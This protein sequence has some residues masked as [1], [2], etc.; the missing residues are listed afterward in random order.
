MNKIF[1]SKKTIIIL[2]LFLA[3]VFSAAVGWFILLHSRQ[4]AEN[5][6][7]FKERLDEAD[8][9]ISLGYT[10]R[11]FNSLEKALELGIS[12]YSL[13]KVLKRAFI[14]AETENRYEKLYSLSETALEKIPGSEALL[15]IFIYSSLRAGHPVMMK[16]KIKDSF[17]QETL[18]Y[19]WAEAYLRDKT[20]MMLLDQ[21]FSPHINRLIHLSSRKN[22]ADLMELGEDLKDERILLDTALLW[23][24]RGKPQEAFGIVL[25]NLKDLMYDETAAYIAY[26]AGQFNTAIE[27]FN[28]LIE[29]Y[30]DR[31]DLIHLSGDINLILKRNQEAKRYYHRVIMSDPD[32]SWKPYLNLARLLE[33]EK[34]FKS[35]HFYRQKAH[36]IFPD[37]KKVII[38]LAKS[39]YIRGDA[40]NAVKILNPFLQKHPED[41]DANMLLLELNKG[42]ASP[43]VYQ[44][45]LW[46]MLNRFPDNELLCKT[47]ITYLLQFNDLKGSRIAVNQFERAT[48]MKTY[49]ILQY[50]GIIEALEGRYQKAS[51][52]FQE[53]LECPDIWQTH[54]NHAVV[55]KELR[56]HSRAVEELMTAETVLS[57]VLST[58]TNK[59][60]LDQNRSV[61]RSKLGEVFLAL[62]DT[63]SAKREL[64]YAVDL[65]HGNL[66]ARLLLKKLEELQKK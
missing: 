18:Q 10:D 11:A 48:G 13:L 1:F 20:G 63:A 8:S 22:P 45:S 7:V 31:I 37:E 61:I 32:Y 49:W 66:H 21:K 55:L 26:D 35:A 62:D 9:A 16:Q 52:F 53:S 57:T 29:R 65:D 44:A 34:D 56:Y 46:Q 17:K 41:L 59:S 36:S 33:E 58:D 64:E 30:P 14:H 23:M 19:L 28:G 24:K 4:T 42:S 6:K 27:R 38:S 54:Y 39:S 47:L 3:I 12:E 60:A 40:G 50:R 25:K 43:I 15:C 2:I 5:K 51:L